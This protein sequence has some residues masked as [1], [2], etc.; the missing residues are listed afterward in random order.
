[1]DGARQAELFKVLSVESR[2]RII[3]LLKQKGPLG[4]SELSEAIGITP[5]AVSQH[6]KVL[7]YAGLVSSER[8]GYCLP[9][10][11]DPAALE[12]C[13]ELLTDVCNCRCRDDSRFR[14]SG[15]E[16]ADSRLSQL[17]KYERKLKKELEGVQSRIKVIKSE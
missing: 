17:K 1:M 5:S 9:Y 2:I 14:G 7:R 16:K 12:Q 11:I 13:G 3:D 6:L 15:M 8:K 4:V 10:E